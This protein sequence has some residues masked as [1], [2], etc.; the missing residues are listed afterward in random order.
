MPLA[1]DTDRRMRKRMFS[2]L[3]VQSTPAF[4]RYTQE[5]D[6]GAAPELMPPDPYDL[7]ISVR[8]WKWLLSRYDKGLKQIASE[9]NAVDT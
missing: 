5:V 1:F 6:F 8:R 3:V 9:P 4:T 7:D 2:L